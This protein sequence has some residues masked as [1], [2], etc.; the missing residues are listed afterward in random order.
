MLDFARLERG[1]AGYHFAEGDLGEVVA[2]AIDVCRYRLDKEKMKLEI[3]IEP[4]LPGVRMDDNAMTLVR[5]TWS[6]TRSSTPRKAEDRGDAARAPG[7]VGLAVRDS[8][9]ACR[10]TSTSA[11]S[12]ASTDARRAAQRAR[13]GHRP[14]AGQAHRRGP[15][16][17]RGADQPGRGQTGWPD[18]SPFEVFLPA[19]VAPGAEPGAASAQRAEAVES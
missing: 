7:L 2:R 8:G 4:E 14:V 19:A 13:H 9:R 17:A 6:T 15:R 18:G 5:S 3:D 16:R 12:S 10:A 1:K 11:S